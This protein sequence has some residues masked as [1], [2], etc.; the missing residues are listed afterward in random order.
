MVY[1]ASK[2]KKRGIKMTIELTK[3][4]VDNLMEFFEFEC[5][6]SIRNNKDIDNMIHMIGLF[7]LFAAVILIDFLPFIL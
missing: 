4:Q 7:L 3:S 1:N 2:Q 6:D 5:I